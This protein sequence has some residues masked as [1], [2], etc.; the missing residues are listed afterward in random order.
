M[1]EGQRVN[2]TANYISWANKSRLWARFLLKPSSNRTFELVEVQLEVTAGQNSR[3]RLVRRL[4]Q[5]NYRWALDL[6]V[7]AVLIVC[8]M[9]VLALVLVSSI[10]RVRAWVLENLDREVSK[11]IA[12]PLACKQFDANTGGFPTSKIINEGQKTTIGLN[13]VATIARGGFRTSANKPSPSL[14][15]NADGL[16]HMPLAWSNSDL[17][18][19]VGWNSEV[20]LTSE[21]SAPISLWRGYGSFWQRFSDQGLGLSLRGSTK[22]VS[23]EE[24][25]GYQLRGSRWVFNGVASSSSVG[26]SSSLD[27]GVGGLKLQGNKKTY[28]YSKYLKSAW[29]L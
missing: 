29:E 27:T 8:E 11:K 24:S 17:G 21:M 23:K 12:T 5:S 6:L 22:G 1:R 14:N 20:D 18:I 10:L 15:Y 19:Q 26:N 3:P 9:L 28:Q 13:S 7:N 25:F 2:M 16:A 4:F